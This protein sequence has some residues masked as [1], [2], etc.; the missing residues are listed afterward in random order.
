[1][2]RQKLRETMKTYR[3]PLEQP[4]VEVVVELLNLVFGSS[5][6]SEFYW[7]NTITRH[8]LD[9]F[10]TVHLLSWLCSL[11]CFPPASDFLA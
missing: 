3:V 10:G 5:Q 11:G 7:R 9:K 4:Y 2:L 6:Q 1:M 8:V